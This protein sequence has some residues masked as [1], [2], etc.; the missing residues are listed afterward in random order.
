MVGQTPL[1]GSEAK[2]PRFARADG[3]CHVDRIGDCHKEVATDGVREASRARAL[4]VAGR[5]QGCVNGPAIGEHPFTCGGAPR[6]CD[7]LRN[8]GR[9]R[10]ALDGPGATPMSFFP[11]DLARLFA[12]HREFVMPKAVTVVLFIFWIFMAYRAF[13][14]G[15]VM[16]AG[17]LALVGIVLTAYRYSAAQK[18]A[19]AKSQSSAS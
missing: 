6:H 17:V 15:D 8:L 16:M 2:P 14:R 10:R 18:I 11:P 5:T 7:G 1:C 13:E 9:K 4:A 3:S 19:K 12:E